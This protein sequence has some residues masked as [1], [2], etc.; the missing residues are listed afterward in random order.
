[1]QTESACWLVGREG[2]T[3]G[4]LSARKP[5]PGI[6]LWSAQSAMQK[7]THI[8]PLNTFLLSFESRNSDIAVSWLGGVWLATNC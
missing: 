5:L 6:L 3:T 7:R 8:A 4:Q 2:L 1:M